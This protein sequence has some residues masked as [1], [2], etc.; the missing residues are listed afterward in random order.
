MLAI[1]LEKKKRGFKIFLFM[2]LNFHILY[3]KSF[4][5]FLYDDII[6]GEMYEKPDNFRVFISNH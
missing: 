2:P 5:H 4:F 6:K 3:W 1:L